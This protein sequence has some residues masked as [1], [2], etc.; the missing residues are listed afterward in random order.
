MVITT[1]EKSSIRSVCSL[2]FKHHINALP[3][4]DRHRH[5]V[6]IVTKDDIFHCFYP[7]Y[8]EYITNLF[9]TNNLRSDT[10]EFQEIIQKSVQVVMNKHVLF[11]RPDTSIMIA[12]A[13]MVSQ[14]VSQLPVIDDNRK[15][16][17]VVSKGD[18]FY[19]LCR[20]NKKSLLNKIK[21]PLR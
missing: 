11:T 20:L 6:G 14:R 21:L 9:S 15:L 4:I 2:F 10:N 7:D 13:R 19:G 1:T 16:V 12:L 17:G 3:V 18:I 5:V 8:T